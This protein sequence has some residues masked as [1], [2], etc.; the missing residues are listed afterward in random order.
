MITN[1]GKV[2]VQLPPEKTE[3][4]PRFI[5]IPEFNSVYETLKPNSIRDSVARIC[6]TGSTVI[7]IKVIFLD[8]FNLDSFKIVMFLTFVFILFFVTIWVYS[9]KSRWLLCA[10]LSTVVFFLVIAY[11]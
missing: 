10:I 11:L 6:F 5:E 2:T 4:A 3:S 8:N 1:P 7:L 9:P